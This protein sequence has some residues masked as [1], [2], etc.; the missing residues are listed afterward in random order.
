MSLPFMTSIGPIW[1]PDMSFISPLFGS[2]VADGE[3]DGICI[4]MLICIGDI[5]EGDAFGVGVGGVGVG[6]G[7]A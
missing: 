2:A 4:G 6:D 1:W 7:I 5:G 3:G